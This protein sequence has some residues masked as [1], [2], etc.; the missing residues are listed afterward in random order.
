MKDGYILDYEGQEVNDLLGKVKT[1]TI[2]DNA[3][4][5]SRGLMGAADKRKLDNIEN[6]DTISNSDIDNIIK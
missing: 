6:I 2:Y 4:T 5:S 3:T 1:K